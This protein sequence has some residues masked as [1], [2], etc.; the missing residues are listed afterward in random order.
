MIECVESLHRPFSMN[1]NIVSSQSVSDSPHTK[2][3]IASLTNPMKTHLSRKSL[4][5]ATLAL[6]A[7]FGLTQLA[8]APPTIWSDPNGGD[9]SVPA[10]WTAGTP[11]ATND[12]QFGDVG[13]GHTT[14]ND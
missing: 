1:E 14:T 2:L 8:D 6:A 4:L 12:V 11:G 10:N 3:E 7:F 5:P 9:R 13:A